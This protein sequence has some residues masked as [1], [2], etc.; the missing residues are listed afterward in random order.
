MKLRYISK[1]TAAVP[2][3]KV[4]F[5]MAAVLAAT[6]ASGCDVDVRN[7]SKLAT[8]QGASICVI[9]V[10]KGEQLH[11]VQTGQ[12]PGSRKSEIKI[13]D[14]TKNGVA[15][16]VSS[17]IYSAECSKAK[18]TLNYDGSIGDA[19]TE[20]EE[21]KNRKFRPLAVLKSFL[22]VNEIKVTPTEN[23]GEAKVSLSMQ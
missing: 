18:F 5:A 3:K 17:E 14:I 6:L 16:E 15:V 11:S 12:G 23:P 2:Q 13:T 7:I 8:C 9:T 1:Q 19:Q 20:G 10:R 21:L 4:G 22:G